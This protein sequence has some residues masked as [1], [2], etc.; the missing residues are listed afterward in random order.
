M[1]VSA[2]QAAPTSLRDPVGHN[3]RS[4]R[5]SSCAK[6]VPAMMV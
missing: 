4:I 5:P 6:P 1:Q 3:V 2:G